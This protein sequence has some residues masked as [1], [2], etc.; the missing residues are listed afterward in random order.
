MGVGSGTRVLVVGGG[1][2][3]H[4]LCWKLRQS[5]RIGALYCAPGNGGIEQ[6]ATRIDIGARDTERL[7]DWALENRIDLVVVGP[8]DPLADGLVNQIIARGVKA[9]GPT[10]AAAEI[11]W[12]KAWAKRF[13]IENGIPS[14]AAADFDGAEAAHNYVDSVEHRVVVKADGLAVGKGVFV[15]DDRGEAHRAID[16]IMVARVFGAAGARVVVEERIVGREVSATAICDGSTYRMLPLAC[17][18]KAINDGNRGPNTGGMGTYSPPL[19]ATPELSRAIEM[20][21]IAPAVRG[22]ARAGRPFTGFLYPGIMMTEKGPCVFEFNARL[23]DPEAQV[24]L[25]RL[26]DDLLDILEKAADGRLSET[27]PALS[28]SA[29]AAC[30]VIMAS[31]GYPGEYDFGKAISGL[32][33]IAP[34]TIVFHAGTRRVNDRYVTAGGRVLGVTAVGATVAEARTRAYADVARVSFEGAHYRR[35][36]GQP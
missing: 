25:P 26:A 24:L 31:R 10:R 11:E 3:E 32:D 4:T 8:D 35:D 29:D 9:F 36:I 23:G 19:F 15:C 5:P 7:A 1:G 16:A 28:L 14:T 12:S 21:I 2:R 27:P 34:E 20:T 33:A 18:H 22:M 17:D 6:V 30:C 13:C